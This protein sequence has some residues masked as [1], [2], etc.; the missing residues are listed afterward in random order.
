MGSLLLWGAMMG[1]SG[2][3]KEAAGSSL[4][5]QRVTVAPVL[6]SESARQLRLSGT[7]EA[8]RT[9]PLGF[10]VP[11]IVQEVLVRE[12]EQ[13]QAGQILAR[14]SER[15]ARDALGIA[16]SKAAQAAD[17]Y[18][19]L[20]P[21]YRNQTLPEVKWVEVEAAREQARLM[22][23]MAQKNVA[24][25]TLRAPEK[26]ILAR[27]NVEVGASIAPGVPA[28]S[29]VQTQK[30]YAVVSVPETH[31]T[32]TQIGQAAQVQVGA[33]G[34]SYSGAIREIGMLAD[35]LTRTY[36]VKILLDNEVGELR[37][38]MIAEVYL[39]QELDA[40]ALVVPPAAVRL[41]E[42]GQNFVYV[43]Q[44]EDQTL[45]KQPV[46]LGGYVAE[47]L[48]V[49]EGLTEGERVVISGSPMLASGVRVAIE[50]E[51]P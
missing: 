35:P 12:G 5:V 31:I 40:E 8:E 21:M 28:F 7:L 30:M 3:Q 37:V 2:C 51:K 15:S 11:G 22:V 43:L 29:L 6:R 47:K 44:E 24:D 13:V 26:G 49:K 23:S 50:G 36:P 10:S 25:Q 33:L 39:Q 4:V 46:A 19:R 32:H 48:R 27:R 20:E 14:L 1:L 42:Q 17:A 41:D 18:R 9:L 38:G 45:K 34:K 16:E